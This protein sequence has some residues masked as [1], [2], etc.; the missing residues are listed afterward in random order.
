MSICNICGNS[1]NNQILITHYIDNSLGKVIVQ[2][3]ED[4][5]DELGI[6]DILQDKFLL[7]D[8]ETN[9]NE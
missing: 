7:N 8:E 4:C 6:S 9:K 1:R 2:I 5:Y 3:C